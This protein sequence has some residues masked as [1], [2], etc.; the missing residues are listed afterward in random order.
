MDNQPQIIDGPKAE[1]ALGELS[2][3]TAYMTCIVAVLDE[4]SSEKI[5]KEIVRLL[6]RALLRP[7]ERGEDFLTTQLNSRLNS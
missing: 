2:R 7:T 1:E 5:T 4:L 6:L 3:L